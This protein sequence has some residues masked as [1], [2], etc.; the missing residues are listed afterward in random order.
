[1]VGKRSGR[2]WRWVVF[3]AGL[4]AVVLLGTPFLHHDLDCH[5]KSPTHCTACTASPLASR[6]ETGVGLLASPLSAA[7]D[8]VVVRTARP[9]SAPRTHADGRAPPA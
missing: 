4:Y 2:A 3:A 6:V 8:V 7:G 5:L 1:M 9:W